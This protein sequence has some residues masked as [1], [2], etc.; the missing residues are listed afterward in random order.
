MGFN[1]SGIVINK[2]YKD[3]L[4]DLTKQ[5]NWQLQFD[6]EIDFETASENWKD[7][8]ICDIYFSDK[9]TILFINMDMCVDAWKINDGNS[10]TFALSETSMAF[11]LNYCVGTETV[12]SIME[13][14][15]EVMNDEGQKL[16]VDEQSADTS[17]I[18]WGQVGEVLGKSFWDIE[19]EEKAYRYK[20]VTKEKKPEKTPDTVPETPAPSHEE[21]NE[22]IE[23]YIREGNE[24]VE[25]INSFV[26]KNKS[27]KNRHGKMIYLCKTNVEFPKIN[28][29]SLKQNTD[30][31]KIERILNEKYGPGYLVT[32][33]TEKT[34]F[35]EGL[36]QL[37]GKR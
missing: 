29:D 16:A 14:N 3:N 15:G 18:I 24:K 25:E 9:G 12:R 33:K 5:F 27:N 2:N 10:L 31:L 4:N 36:K 6:T 7:E 22:M 32:F 28:M 8:G 21:I 23:I 20:F 26:S 1:I 37:F 13:V 17:E 11:N 19:P 34:S 30:I 35:F